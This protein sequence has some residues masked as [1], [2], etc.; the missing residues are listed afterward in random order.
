MGDSEGGGGLPS[1]SNA[2]L[3][4]LFKPSP[5]IDIVKFWQ[6]IVEIVLRGAC[7]VSLYCVELLLKLY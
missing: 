3:I 1:V 4:A 6:G 2:M 7:L 5:S